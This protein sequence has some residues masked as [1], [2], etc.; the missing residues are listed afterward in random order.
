M[1]TR[2]SFYTKE[3]VSEKVLPYLCLSKKP[4]LKKK[5]NSKVVCRLLTGNK[6][7]GLGIIVGGRMED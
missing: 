1:V 4:N 6:S 3:K 5:K 7:Q 2:T